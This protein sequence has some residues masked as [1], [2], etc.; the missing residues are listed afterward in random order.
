MY[1][2]AVPVGCSWRVTDVDRT[3]ARRAA[4]FNHPTLEYSLVYRLVCRAPSYSS[5]NAA[6]SSRQKAGISGTT[7]P[8]TE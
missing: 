2:D 4:S 1:G 8:Q 7:R 6:T 3:P 5:A